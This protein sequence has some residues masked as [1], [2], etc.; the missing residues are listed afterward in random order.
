[1]S[2]DNDRLTADEPVCTDETLADMTDDGARRIG[3]LA[4]E[5]GVSLRT[6]RFYEDKG[7]ISPQRVGNTRLYYH[8]DIARLRLIMLGRK[9][10]FSLR[11]VKQ[12]MDLYDPT[13]S[14]IRQMKA[15][16]DRSSRQMG[17]LEKQKVELDSAID[18]L[19]GLMDTAKT[20][21]A[22]NTARPN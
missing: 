2:N 13:G 9:V 1:M 16:L 10:G 3:D 14:N 20:Q 11:E 18:A 6:L 5:F 4:S 22:K 21:L 17:R 15:L 8:R 19:Q 7:L 12:I